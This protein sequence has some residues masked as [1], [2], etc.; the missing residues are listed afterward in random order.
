MRVLLNTPF[1]SRVKLPDESAPVI[2]LV[3]TFVG[4]GCAFGVIVGGWSEELVGDA[5]QE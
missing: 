2:G 3:T 1:W 4:K 5:V